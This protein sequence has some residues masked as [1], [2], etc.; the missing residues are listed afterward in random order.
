MASEVRARPIVKWA[1]GKTALLPE[2]LARVPDSFDT[3]YEPFAGGAALFFALAPR[4]AVLSDANAD[5][6][7]MYRAVATSPEA[8]I[9]RLAD[10][11]R[12]HSRRHY[13]LTRDRWN[14]GRSST[15]PQRSAA[16]IYLNKTCFNGLWRVNRA[17]EFN[18]PMGRYT[19]P[20]ICDA[21]A[22]R[23]AAPLLYRA[24]TRV[25]DFRRSVVDAVRGD[26]LYIDP[27]YH[28]VIP[29]SFTRYAAQDFGPE[30]QISLADTVNGLVKRGCKVLLS[31]SDT[32]LI[33]SLY[34]RYRIDRVM[35]RRS[36]N[37]NAKKRGPVAEVLVMAG[38]SPRVSR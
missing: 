34:R 36:V 10:H 37:S 18:V 24:G 7:A 2:L 35:C 31:N 6:I 30:E 28:A 13:Y 22:I 33:R 25:L 19:N 38:Y 8:V 27:P 21:E 11:K 17:G 29:T 12:R 14:G 26:F 9:R 20:T 1:G 15:L 32:P 5:L 3:Y 23:A 16:F 4:V